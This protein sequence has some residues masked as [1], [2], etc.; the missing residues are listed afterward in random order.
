M[1]KMTGGQIH[2]FSILNSLMIMI[3]LSGMV[4]MILLRTLHRDITKYN[5][6]ASAEEA[7]EETGWKLVHADVFR[8]PQFSKLLVVSVGSGVQ[9]LLM[10]VVTLLFALLGFLSPARRGV[11]LQSMMLLFTFM[12]FFAGYAQ[13]RLYK[14]FNGEDW[15]Q[16]TFLTAFLYP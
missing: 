13:A 3:F 12:G 10:S 11:P 6:K 7:A 8:K 16:T 5:E 4:A 2:W 1:G 9:I 14:V 15:K